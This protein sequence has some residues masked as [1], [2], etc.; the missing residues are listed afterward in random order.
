MLRAVPLPGSHRQPPRLE[1]VRVAG[2]PTLQVLCVRGLP[3]ATVVTVPRARPAFSEPGWGSTRLRVPGFDEKQSAEYLAFRSVH[4]SL[5]SGEDVGGPAIAS[6]APAD[7]LDAMLEIHA[8]LIRSTRALG[9][10]SPERLD[11]FVVSAADAAAVAQLFAAS[12][13]PS[14]AAAPFG[15]AGATAGG[16]DSAAATSGASRE[17]GSE[18]PGAAGEGSVEVRWQ[19]SDADA[20]MRLELRFAQTA[21]RE[22][23]AVLA[24][25]A[26]AIVLGGPHSGIGTYP[27]CR[28][29]IQFDKPTPAELPARVDELRSALRAVRDGGLPPA[30]ADA[31][32]RVARTRQLVSL[33]GSTAIAKALARG[34]SNPWDLH[35]E[36]SPQ[37][38]SEWARLALAGAALRIDVAGGGDEAR[39]ATE[40]LRAELG[41][42]SGP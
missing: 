4:A 30:Q 28:L 33:T 11:V 8:R 27:D 18:A 1:S 7:S 31:A 25:R 14:E 35:D 20:S 15:G 29:F 37:V 38:W 2:G 41:G 42:R 17:A 26:L 5:A 10:R 22:A 34:E 32:L 23:H 6:D 16:H 9:Q 13:G 36:L 3:A 21:C 40:R 39:A 12:W 24:A 19:P